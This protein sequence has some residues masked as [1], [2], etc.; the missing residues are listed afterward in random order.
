MTRVPA[1]F[2]VS[3]NRLNLGSRSM[4]AKVYILDGAS[5]IFIT[6]TTVRYGEGS[7]RRNSR[8]RRRTVGGDHC[9]DAGMP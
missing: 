4:K 2:S 7:S 5:Q 6:I 3:L 9:N 8:I 1:G